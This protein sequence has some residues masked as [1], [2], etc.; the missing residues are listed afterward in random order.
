MGFYSSCGQ[1]YITIFPPCQPFPAN[2][3]KSGF[4]NLGGRKQIILIDECPFLYFMKSA[5][6]APTRSAASMKASATGGSTSPIS[7]PAP[8]ANAAAP[9]VFAN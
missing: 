9:K 5:A 7:A 6:P 3:L 2:N 8:K 1:D 4:K